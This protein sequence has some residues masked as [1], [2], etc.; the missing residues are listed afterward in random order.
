[1]STAPRGRGANP[2]PWR[3]VCDMAAGFA[4]IRRLE[5]GNPPMTTADAFKDVFDAD[6]KL[7]TY[8]D[9]KRAWRA[10]GLVTGERDRW[11]GYG[12]TEAGEWLT[13]MKSWRQRR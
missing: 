13:F 9:Q 6:F 4:A 1:M 3:Y 7:T 12:R 8:G 11:I 10:A 5:D 2:W